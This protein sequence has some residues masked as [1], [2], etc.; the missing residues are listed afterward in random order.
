M[1]QEQRGEYETVVCYELR[2]GN[3]IW[4]HS[5]LTS[6]NEVTSGKGPRATP[7]I[8]GGRVYSLGATGILN[9]L[10]GRAGRKIWST[11]VLLDHNVEN[12]LFGM[13][14]SPLVT[15]GVVV[16]SPGGKNASLVAYDELTGRPVWSKGHASASYS[17]AQ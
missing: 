1:T 8:H 9:C 10:D 11:N 4:V 6:F 7:A 12:A 16:V 3:E 2:T 14:G 5:D 15:N 13:S 17:S